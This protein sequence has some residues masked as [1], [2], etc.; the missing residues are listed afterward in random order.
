MATGVDGAPRHPPLSG[1]S[2]WTSITR[3]PSVD[4]RLGSLEELAGLLDASRQ[5]A[6]YTLSAPSKE[7][8]TAA[9]EEN[10]DDDDDEGVGVHGAGCYQIARTGSSVSIERFD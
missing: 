8:A 6:P 5:K 7:E 10:N 9:K 1:S 2:E 3:M 4:G